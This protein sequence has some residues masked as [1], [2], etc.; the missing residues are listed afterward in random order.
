MESK[1]EIIK[2][3]MLK[4]LQGVDIGEVYPK[5]Y[6]KDEVHN[7]GES[8]FK[9]FKDLGGVEIVKEEAPKVP[10][11]PEGINLNTMT[12]AQLVEFAA[13]ELDLVLEV[14]SLKSDLIEAIEEKL[15]DT[16]N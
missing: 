7:I 1:K 2:V 5:F 9:A 10:K 3:K 4:T 8:L 13:K 16:I 15:K 14:D 6:K 12:K 11:E